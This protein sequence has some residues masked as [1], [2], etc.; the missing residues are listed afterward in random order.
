M[1]RKTR[2]LVVALAVSGLV[3][4]GAVAA[5]QLAHADVAGTCTSGGADANCNVSE[6]ITAP[7]SISVT[8]SVTPSDQYPTYSYTLQC[9]LGSQSTTTTGSGAFHSPYTVAIPLP[10]ASPDSCT[11][12]VTAQIP[13]AN[14]YDEISLT[15]DYTTGPST[16]TS[17]PV[18]LVRGYGGKCLDDRA[19][20]SANG[21]QVIIWTCNSADSAQGWTYTNDE[22]VHNGRCA[23][24]QSNGGSGS[25]V[26]LW[27][28]DGASNEL[29]SHPS[30]GEFVLYSSSHGILCLDDPAYSKTNRTQLIV[31]ACRNSSNQHWSV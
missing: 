30:N 24:D 6:T 8:V 28:C 20:S 25:K 12:S 31:Y 22:L 11:I 13:T 16:S 15:V 7:T 3:A 29:W 4:A 26:I 10:Y 27:T 5:S 1:I 21:T 19:N 18:P 23:N 14:V 17:G 9:S 2:R